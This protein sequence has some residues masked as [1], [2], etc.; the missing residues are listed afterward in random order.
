M[1]IYGWTATPV[2]SVYVVASTD[3]GK[4]WGPL[5]TVGTDASTHYGYTETSIAYLG[6]STVLAISRNNLTTAL[7]QF[8]STD[9]G[10]TWT[11]QGLTTF[12]SYTHG[13]PV[14]VPFTDASGFQKVTLYANRYTGGQ[15]V[16]AI[17]G[18][19][20]N[21]IAG[22][23]GWDA[24]TFTNIG[25]FSGGG[26][27]AAVV[28][29]YGA[30]YG[31]SFYTSEESASVA[32]IVFFRTPLQAVPLVF[33]QGMLFETNHTTTPI[34]WRITDD[35]GYGFQ[36]TN[37]NSLDCDWEINVN[38]TCLFNYAGYH[39]GTTKYR[40]MAIY[41]GKAGIV[42]TFDGPSGTTRIVPPSSCTG[43]PSGTLY[44]N[45]GVAGFCP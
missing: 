23:S 34:P 33:K 38:D 29:P 28:Q 24:S 6:G 14:L 3:G 31:L 13:A 45:G 32:D 39:G 25:V 35:G 4:T 40:S 10:N 20:S 5:I 26:G 2:Y 30:P 44:N 8:L 9:N 11:S 42:A 7:A 43:L 12:D 41:N 16:Q 21:L 18:F 1:P 36:I 37:E 19:A 27:Y 17:T 22:P 15:Q